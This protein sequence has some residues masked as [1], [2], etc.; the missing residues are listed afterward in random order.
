MGYDHVKEPK[1]RQESKG[2]DKKGGSGNGNPYSSKH[3]RMQS[4]LF[5]KRASMPQT[6]KTSNPNPTK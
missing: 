5:E 2:K 6:T 3:V 4:A 1:T